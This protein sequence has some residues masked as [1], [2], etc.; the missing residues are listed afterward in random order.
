MGIEN[1]SLIQMQVEDRAI[2]FL[3]QNWTSSL[4]FEVK[5]FVPDQTLVCIHVPLWLRGSG[6][7]LLDQAAWLC[8]FGIGLAFSLGVLTCRLIPADLGSH[9]PRKGQT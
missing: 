4:V 7:N 9:H 2:P 5:R 3:H 6:S 8:C 1:R